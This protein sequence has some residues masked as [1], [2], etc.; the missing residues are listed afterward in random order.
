MPN[1]WFLVLVDAMPWSLSTAVCP[2]AVCSSFPLSCK[3]RCDEKFEGSVIIM[4]ASISW[5][6]TGSRQRQARSKLNAQQLCAVSTSSSPSS[7]HL[8]EARRSVACI[9]PGPE[10]L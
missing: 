4:T 3:C 2:P 10:V 6:L 7:L 1:L 8:S 9:F 5:S